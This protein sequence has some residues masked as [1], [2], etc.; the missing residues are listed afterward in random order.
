MLVRAAAGANAADVNTDC[1]V[2]L[3]VGVSSKTAVHSM[4]PVAVDT[5]ATYDTVA[6]DVACVDVP[7]TPGDNDDQPRAAPPP[8]ASS[9]ATALH[10]A[11]STR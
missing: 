7:G 2:S 11:N 9:P 1:C 8:S 10:E 6:V 5:A 3:S 4:V